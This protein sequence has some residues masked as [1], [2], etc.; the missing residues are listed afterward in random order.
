MIEHLDW[1]L[2]VATPAGTKL[3]IST[4]KVDVQEP[5]RRLLMLNSVKPMKNSN[6]S[7][8]ADSRNFTTVSGSSGNRS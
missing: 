3:T 1:T 6:A 5:T 4:L 8:V 2:L 7:V